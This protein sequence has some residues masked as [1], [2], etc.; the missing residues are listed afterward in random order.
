MQ[1]HLITLNDG[2][3]LVALLRE[4]VATEERLS[5]QGVDVARVTPE[6]EQEEENVRV[7]P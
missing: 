3:R 6:K 1:A 5:F 2:V 7:R 4:E